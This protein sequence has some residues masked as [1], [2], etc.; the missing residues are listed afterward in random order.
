MPFI[1]G[2]K[3][4]LIYPFED[5]DWV[6]K[7]WPLPLIAAIPVLGLISVILLKG[8]RF[9]MVKRIAQGSHELPPFRPI[10]MLKTGALLW[11]VMMGHMFIPGVL[12]SILGIGGPLGF[13]ADL[14]DILTEGF[15]AWAKSQ[16]SD[17]LLTILV[18]LTWGVISFPVFQSGMIRYALSGDWKTLLN[19]PANFLLFVRHA[20]YFLKFYIYWVLLS[21]GI[22]LAD[23]VLAFTGI[24]L[25][26]VPVFTVC[27]YYITTAHEL[28]LLA[29]KVNNTK[30]A[31][32]IAP[33]A[34]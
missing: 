10:P 9:E 28:G 11:V 17:W 29:R 16:P 4:S 1:E 23:S 3:Q 8:W 13:V 14:Y 2:I 32:E 15:S 20:H 33:T 34:A 30:A 31:S 6:S 21:L 22:F 5:R 26:L 27:A 24:G 12:C 7:L 18:Y 19:A 25:L